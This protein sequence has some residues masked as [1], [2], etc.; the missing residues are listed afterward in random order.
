[1]SLD[2]Y[3]T[4]REPSEEDPRARAIFNGPINPELLMQMLGGA[5]VS[6]TGN[7]REDEPSVVV[8]EHPVTQAELEAALAAY[9]R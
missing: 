4:A 6:T 7:Y 3:E 1:M 5:G 2:D 8:A 9:P